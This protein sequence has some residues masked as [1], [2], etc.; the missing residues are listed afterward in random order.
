MDKVIIEKAVPLLDKRFI[1]V[2]D[3]QY[4]HGKHYFDATR[5]DIDSLVA[6]MSDDEFIH[7]LPNAVTCAVVCCPDLG[8]PLLLLTYEYRYPTGRFLLSPPAGLIDKED[9]GDGEYA[10]FTAAKREM[11][12]ETGLRFE[13]GDDIHIIN[14]LL[15]SSPGLTDESNAMACIIKRHFHDEMLSQAG[16]EGSE[17]FDG[18]QLLTVEEARKVLTDGRDRNGNFYSVYTWIALMY[19][20]SGMWKE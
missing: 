9:G 8:E 13:E 7:Q 2:F 10:I 16:A 19:F 18:F 17:C 1:R 6:T 11:F 14:P 15:F 3:L 12:E 4:G 20:V 5:N